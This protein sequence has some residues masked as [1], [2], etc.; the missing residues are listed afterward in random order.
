METERERPALLRGKLGKEWLIVVELKESPRTQV[1]P[2]RVKKL[3]Y[4]GEGLG[5]CTML[6]E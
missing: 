3:H 1:F 2:T 5:T 6:G 4:S